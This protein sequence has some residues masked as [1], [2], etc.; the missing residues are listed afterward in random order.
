MKIGDNIEVRDREESYININPIQAGGRLTL[1]ARKALLAYGDGYS[2]CDH[3]LSPFRL[4][5]IK[6][7]PIADF[8]EDLAEFLNMDVVRVVPGA[9]RGFQAVAQA[10]LQ[11]GDIVLVSSLAHYTL[12]LAI[13]EVGAVW[14]EIPAN[15]DNIVTAELALKKV[16]S[17][18]KELGK[19][20]KLV[21]VS[22]F[23]S[24]F[25]NEHE[26]KGIAEVAH[27]FGIPFLCNGAYTVG[28]MPVDGKEIEA[29]FIVGSG[30][31]S[32]AAPAPTGVLATTEEFAGILFRVTEERGDI[33]GRRFGIKEIG[34]LGCTVMGAPLVAMMASFPMVKQRVKNWREEVEKANHFAEQFLRI[35]GNRVASEMPRKHTLTKV[36]T[37]LSFGQVAAKHRERGYFLYSALKKRG[38][39][40]LIPG[41]TKEWKLSTYNLNWK[42]VKYLESAFLEIAKENGLRVKGGVVANSLDEKTRPKSFP[43][44]TQVRG[45]EHPVC[46]L[47]YELR[48]IFLGRGLN[49]VINPAIIGEEEVYKQYGR[50]APLILDRVYYLAGLP[51]PDIGLSDATIEKIRAI[52]PNFSEKEKLQ[53]L[54]RDYKKGNIESDDFVETLTKRLKISQSQGITVIDKVFPEFKGLRPEPTRKTLRSHMTALW[55]P[56]LAR[57]QERGLLPVR[58]FSIGPRFRREQRED[59]HHLYESTTASIVIMDDNFTFEDGK[60]LTKKILNTLGIEE[61]KFKIKEVTS[62]YYE[63]STDTEVYINLGG[64]II[65]VAN[66]GFYSPISLANYGIKHR[67]FNVGFGV[68]RL[69]MTFENVHDIRLLVYPHLYGEVTYS[70]AEIA[71]LLEAK[72]RPTSREG[73]E[74]AKIS[75]D[76]AV[77]NKDKT[78]P[79]KILAYDGDLLDANV[80]IYI[81]N[82]DEG[83]PLL[84]YAA[85]NEVYI[86]NGNIYG[87]PPERGNLTG[88]FLE[89]FE[90]GV[91]TELKFL[92]LAIQGAIADLE[93][94]VKR[95]VPAF[96]VRYKIIKTH[97]EINLFIPER[98][99]NY[100]TGCHKRI[101][102]GGPIFAGVKAE[103]R[104]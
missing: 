17:V 44:H 57:V 46:K 62:N 90:K 102:V 76:V 94:A 75:I 93:E 20:P 38:I 63:P 28:I 95:K 15:E 87:L 82:W 12:C 32:M 23:D 104:F 45:R 40:G 70:D 88:E 6:R 48:E 59:A 74:I 98:V 68:E 21:A 101:K 47:A 18:K 22:H 77:R 11:K 91:N 55:F 31:K 8:H 13:E 33:T 9:R 80:K 19:L 85:L 53:Q 83:K 10:I 99:M 96:D 66:L 65:E 51:R 34:L 67:V 54:L 100:I 84:S 41:A 2:V 5:Y 52:I 50:E 42:Q 1:E 73:E 24:S 26:V 58:L 7:P 56:V 61:V 3:C 37:E 103:I 86:Y 49:E 4:D 39:I 36:N 43:V 92:S 14:K 25:G 89:A 64:Q 79:S 97:G 60:E 16:E 71:N 69:A 30:H 27:N 29:D 78:G 81:Y 72:K 35:E